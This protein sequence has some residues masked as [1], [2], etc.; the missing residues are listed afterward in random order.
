MS[1]FENDNTR[2]TQA[3]LWNSLTTEQQ[4]QVLEAYEESEDEST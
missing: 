1:D 3:A 2:A 4:I